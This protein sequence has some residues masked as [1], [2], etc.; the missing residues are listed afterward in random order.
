MEK[1]TAVE[2]LR[3]FLGR[4]RKTDAIA[5]GDRHWSTDVKPVI[6]TDSEE[7]ALEWILGMLT[8]VPGKKSR[9]KPPRVEVARSERRKERV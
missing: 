4:S 5:V 9:K 1:D 8:S 6:V 3:R 7:E 2:L